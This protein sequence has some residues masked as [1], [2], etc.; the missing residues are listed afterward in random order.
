[1][2]PPAVTMLAAVV[3]PT[4]VSTQPGAWNSTAP[5]KMA[6]A[7]L[8]IRPLRILSFPC[9]KVPLMI[10]SEPAC[11]RSDTIAADGP[12][13]NHAVQRGRFAIWRRRG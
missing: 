5:L 7:S 4:A 2:T 12:F 6:S 11:G 10:V 9:K 13:V 1:M 8:L 3:S